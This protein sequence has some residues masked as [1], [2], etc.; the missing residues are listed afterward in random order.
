MRRAPSVAACFGALLLM[1]VLCAAAGLRRAVTVA[2]R[3]GSISHDAHTAARV[4]VDTAANLALAAAFYPRRA[5]CLE[6]SLTLCWLL[7]RRSIAAALRIGVQPL[8]FHAHAWVEV[9][10]RAINERE[11]VTAGF[12]V[13]DL[14][15]A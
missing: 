13:F 8:P 12:V 15:R 3:S 7:R 11:D 6:Q 2:T 5:L 14:G 4:S 10:G 1:D 9:D